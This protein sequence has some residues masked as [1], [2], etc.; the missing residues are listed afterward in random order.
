[1]S[2]GWRTGGWEKRAQRSA[3]PK[4]GSK[5]PLT[6]AAAPKPKKRLKKVNHTE[7]PLTTIILAK[8][9]NYEGDFPTLIFSRFYDC[10]RE[11]NIGR[12]NHYLRINISRKGGEQ[13][14]QD[15]QFLTDDRISIPVPLSHIE[16]ISMISGMSPCEELLKVYY[17][18]F[19]FKANIAHWKRII[20]KRIEV[21]AKKQTDFLAIPEVED[22]PDYETKIAKQIS[23]EPAEDDEATEEVNAEQDIEEQ[24]IE[25]LDE[26][27]AEE[28]AKWKL[29]EKKRKEKE[30]RARKILEA[31]KKRES[32]IKKK[33]LAGVAV[34]KAA[35]SIKKAEENLAREEQK[36]VDIATNYGHWLRYFHDEVTNDEAY[37]YFLNELQVG[38]DHAEAEEDY[39][40]DDVQMEVDDPQFEQT[41]AEP[42][43]EEY[44][45]E[46]EETQALPDPDDVVGGEEVP[47]TPANDAVEAVEAA[48]VQEVQ[49]EELPIQHDKIVDTP[50]W[51]AIL[52]KK[53]LAKFYASAV[54]NSICGKEVLEK[55]SLIFLKY[56]PKHKSKIVLKNVTYLGAEVHL[57]ELNSI[58]EG[59]WNGIL[60]KPNDLLK[61]M[62]PYSLEKTL[63]YLA[64]THQRAEV[65]DNIVDTCSLCERTIKRMFMEKH[66]TKYCL[67]RKE[68]CKYC[69]DYFVFDKIREHWASDCP[70]FPVSCILNCNQKHPRAMEGEHQKVCTNATVHCE[71]YNIGC[72]VELKRKQLQKHMKDEASNHLKLIKTQLAIVTGYLAEREPALA[73]LMN[74]TP[75]PREEISENENGEDGGADN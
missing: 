57:K 5:R 31:L 60:K 30:R 22:E 55:V 29:A 44:H 9:G 59:P 11:A 62:S 26:R 10:T 47:E 34:E 42:L 28:L 53:P 50:V 8:P 48:E 43:N 14:H 32:A 35:L 58:I 38:M 25:E 54:V 17:D 15:E 46:T 37:E 12:K 1:M 71:F 33:N 36:L 51:I 56:H 74:P 3:S 39:N 41:T 45:Q 73:Q 75:P 13:E 68:L 21:H 67:K 40:P 24:Q 19:T 64:L 63:H 16:G 72:L 49:E 27:Q 6:K 23:F 52:L 66:L 18:R 65:I 61:G 70:M 2:A 7:L 69:E 20:A 4:V